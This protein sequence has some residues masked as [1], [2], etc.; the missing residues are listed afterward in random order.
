MARLIGDLI[1]IILVLGASAVLAGI[2]T[3]QHRVRIVG[4]V[5]RL[6]I[7]LRLLTDS[8]KRVTMVGYSA[9]LANESEEGTLGNLQGPLY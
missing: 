4:H 7:V 2:T 9:V 6:I 5:A 1:V 8:T 3:I